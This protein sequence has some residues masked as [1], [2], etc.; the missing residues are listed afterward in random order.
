[1]ANT[2]IISVADYLS[3][4]WVDNTGAITISSQ[5]NYLVGTPGAGEYRNFF[6]F[7]LSSIPDGET[8]LSAQFIIYNT[9]YS[10]PG[11]GGYQSSDA[12]ETY[13]LFSIDDTD[14][15]LLRA[16]ATGL[17]SAFVDLGDGELFSSGTIFSSDSSGA[18]TTLDLSSSFISYAQSNLAG[19]VGLGGAIT[20]LGSG[21]GQT[22]FSS[23]HS[24]SLSATRL[25]ITTSAVP[26]PATMGLLGGV[27][28]LG[29]AMVYRRYRQQRMG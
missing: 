11:I 16:D 22:L 5:G 26:E 21:Y 1:M 10:F 4:G 17:V 7:D 19:E 12:T 13:Q 8:I 6:I 29:F 24:L 28:A 23:S 2:Y 14:F 9:P 27:V 18:E 3:R 15:S 25:V 20:S